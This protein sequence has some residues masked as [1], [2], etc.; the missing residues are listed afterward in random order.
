MC[1]HTQIDGALFR[2]NR[3]VLATGGGGLDVGDHAMPDFQL[4]YGVADKPQMVRT[5]VDTV[6]TLPVYASESR[7]L[8]VCELSVDT[9]AESDAVVL[10]GVAL[11]VAAVAEV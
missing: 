1:V 11:V 5:T 4:F 6:V 9:A 2:G 8:L 3:V 10:A 7:E